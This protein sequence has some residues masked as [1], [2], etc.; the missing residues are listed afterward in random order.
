MD[1]HSEVFDAVRKLLEERDNAAI[2]IDGRCGSGKTTLAAALSL[3]FDC[4]VFH[5]DD[6]FLP[7]GMRRLERLAE[8]GG[9]V[10]HERFLHEV[11]VPIREGMPVCYRPYICSKAGFGDVK[12]F[13]KKRLNIVEGSYSLHPSLRDY[14]DLKI[15]LTLDPETQEQRILQRSGP[16]KLTDYKNLWIPMEELYF[17]ELDVQGCCDIILDTGISSPCS[18]V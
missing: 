15:F 10:H 7:A 18:R 12:C 4:N 13:E 1:I 9:N 6:F 3:E 14:Y 11:L 2:A 17:R 16:E 5:M 8:P